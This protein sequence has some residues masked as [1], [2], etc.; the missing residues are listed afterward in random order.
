MSIFRSTHL[1]MLALILS[2]PSHVRD[3]KEG[4]ILIFR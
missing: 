2:A 1:T 3:R 4:Y